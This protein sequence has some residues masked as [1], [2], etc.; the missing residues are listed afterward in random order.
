MKIS[1]PDLCIDVIASSRVV[2]HMGWQTVD[3]HTYIIMGCD[4]KIAVKG[5]PQ[6]GYDVSGGNNNGAWYYGDNF[7][8]V[9]SAV[10]SAL[11]VCPESYR[12][13]DYIMRLVYAAKEAD[14]AYDAF[15]EGKDIF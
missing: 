10:E 14:R 11:E 3:I 15:D 8:T 4:W 1:S 6:N 2:P 13:I 9:K 7:R 12:D 5:N